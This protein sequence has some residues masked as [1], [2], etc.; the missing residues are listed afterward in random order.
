MSTQMTEKEKMTLLVESL[1]KYQLPFI[2]TLV[3]KEQKCL[4]SESEK[5]CLQAIKNYVNKIPLYAQEVK[6]V[7][8]VKEPNI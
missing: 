4:L 7:K 6:E 8:E 2:K 5:D 1:E 3:E